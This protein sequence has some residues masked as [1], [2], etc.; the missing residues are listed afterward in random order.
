MATLW[1]GLTKSFHTHFL[2]QNDLMKRE[3]IKFLVTL[4]ICV[5]PS[6]IRAE[7]TKDA[8]ENLLSVKSSLAWPVRATLVKKKV[9]ECSV[10]NGDGKML[11]RT[12]DPQHPFQVVICT[13]C[14]G[15]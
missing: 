4:S 3:R 15:A 6:S 13:A 14:K 7:A 1:V 9:P 11:R 10:C 8:R 2:E 5:D 12:G